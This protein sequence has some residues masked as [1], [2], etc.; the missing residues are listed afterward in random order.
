MHAAYE[1][2]KERS[3]RTAGVTRAMRGDVLRKIRKLLRSRRQWC[4][5]SHQ[6]EVE[7][8]THTT[9]ASA[10]ATAVGYLGNVSHAVN[11][12]HTRPHPPNTAPAAS[13]AAALRPR[14][15]SWIPAFSFLSVSC[16]PINVALAGKIAGKDRSRPPTTGPQC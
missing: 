14:A 10:S 8:I 2:R 9:P 4:R 16:R 1:P 11:P 3:H 12:K 13:S 6:S 5:R 7:T 15:L